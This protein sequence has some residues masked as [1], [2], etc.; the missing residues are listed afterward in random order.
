M[1]KTNRPDVW[2][3]FLPILTLTTACSKPPDERLVKL[4]ERASDRQQAQNETIANQSQQTTELS[5]GYIDAEA[6]A[7]QELLAL[8]QQ[9]ITADAQSREDLQAIHAQVVQRD[10][11]G[12][13][14]LDELH[15][16]AH[17]S[18]A[19][20]SQAIDRQR[21]EL[22]QE[23]RQ[24]ADDRLRAPV[25]AEAVRFVGGLIV[26]SLPLV[27]VIYLLRRLGGNNEP[28]AAMLDL[29]VSEFVSGEP[30][31]LPPPIQPPALPSASTNS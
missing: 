3:I 23:R 1:P 5:Q 29:L 8:Q 20:R 30:R 6:K 21:D 26:C 7:R 2:T 18:I 17:A 11:D 13:H 31:L 10:A 27:V 12:R 15:R 4:S 28:D 24:I 25:V 22:E 19:T 9:L 14:E 16:Q